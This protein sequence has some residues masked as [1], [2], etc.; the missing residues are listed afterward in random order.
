MRNLPLM[1]ITMRP[2][3]AVRINYDINNFIN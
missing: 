1:I 2:I 3:M